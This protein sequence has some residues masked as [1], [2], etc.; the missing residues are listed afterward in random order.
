MLV[1]SIPYEDA[2]LT[3]KCVLASSITAVYLVMSD[4]DRSGLDTFINNNLFGR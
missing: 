2:K 3:R 4:P 1:Y